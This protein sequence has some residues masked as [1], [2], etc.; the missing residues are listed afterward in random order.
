LQGFPYRKGWRKP[1]EKDFPYN[2]RE[3][4]V[5]GIFDISLYKTGHSFFPSRRTG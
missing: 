2:S 1:K 3:L 4:K 5:S